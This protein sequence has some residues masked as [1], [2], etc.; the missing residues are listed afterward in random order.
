MSELV[1]DYMERTISFRMRLEIWLHLLRC[2]A[3]RHYFDQVRRTV[4][5][6]ANG[7]VSP[8][9]RA[10]EDSLLADARRRQTGGS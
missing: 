4:M 1:T 6:L 7:Q 5:L 3:C 2:P 10:I 9:E 8:P